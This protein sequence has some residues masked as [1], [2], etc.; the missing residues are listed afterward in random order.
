[1]SKSICDRCGA[2]TRG[3]LHAQN[4]LLCP[5]CA[6]VFDKEIQAAK[7]QSKI[8]K[9]NAFFL[10]RRQYRESNANGGSYLLKDIPKLIVDAIVARAEKTGLA[11]RDIIL[12]ALVE[13]LGLRGGKVK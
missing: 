11:Q 5:K 2:I 9:V 1:M 6:R 8:G 13:Y 3:V 12:T 10:A 4:I 7:T